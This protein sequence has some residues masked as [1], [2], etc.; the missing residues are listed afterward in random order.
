M[1]SLIGATDEALIEEIYAR[2]LS[3]KFCDLADESDETEAR[4]ELKN[5]QERHLDE[6]WRLYRSFLED[7][8]PVFDQLLR[9]FLGEKLG[10]NIQTY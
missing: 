8:P 4:K 10:V 3:H 1:S 6:L 9:E 7:P 5:V 2:D